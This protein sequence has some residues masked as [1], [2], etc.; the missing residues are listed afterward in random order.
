MKQAISLFCLLFC[1]VLNAQDRIPYRIFDAKGKP[2]SYAKM[3]RESQKNDIVLFGEY[4]DNSI[5]HW[6]EL[7]FAKD[8][9][10]KK[11]IVLG[12]EMLETDNQTAV[13][14]YLSGTIN[15]KQLDSLARLWPNY[16]TDYKPLVD[17]AKEHKVK[18][19]ATNIP[20]RYA[21]GVYKGGFEAL[22]ALSADEKRFIAPL[23]IK[24]D[25]GLS[26]YKKMVAE[27]GGHGGDNLPKAQ[28]VKDATMAWQ[29]LKNREANTIFIHYNGSYHSDNHEGIFWYLKQENPDVRVVTFATISQNQLKT[30]EKENYNKADFIIV[31]DNDVTKTY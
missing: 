27:M 21:S 25:P 5:V 22:N 2:V 15:Q 26:Q 19:I 10:A 8:M 18:F 3:L 9:S 14:D 20:R 31:T 30:L 16:K 28:A 29:I 4:H 7:V 24:Y 1:L 23:P 6:L 17:F 11:N 13:N 12:A